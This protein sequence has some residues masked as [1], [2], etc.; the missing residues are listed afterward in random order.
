MIG[1]AQTLEA[2]WRALPARKDGLSAVL[3]RD[4]RIQR[5]FAVSAFPDLHRDDHEGIVRFRSS[6]Q[7]GSVVRASRC[8]SGKVKMWRRP[9]P[10]LILPYSAIES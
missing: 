4:H 5:A 1:S 7:V 8:E 2:A 10:R 3:D 6:E 9:L